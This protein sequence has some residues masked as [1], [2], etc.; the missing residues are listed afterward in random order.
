MKRVALLLAMATTLAAAPVRADGQDEAASTELFN[1]GRDAMKRGDYAVACP[2]LAESVRLKASVGALAKL[3]AC[4]EHEHR[5]VSAFTRW[6]QAL[7][8]ARTTA[9]ERLSDVQRELARV[10]ALVPKLVITGAP[11]AG[12]DASIRVDDTTMSTAASLGVA[13]PVEPGRHAVLASAPG[14]KPWT[15]TIDVAPGGATTSIVVPPLED[16]P[17][18]VEAPPV[19]SVAPPPTQTQQASAATA[20]SP[21]VAIPPSPPSRSNP[22]RMVGMVSAGVGLATI[23]VGAAYGIDA[24]RRRDDAHCAGTS[25]PDGASAASLNA[26]KNSANWSTG[27][28]ATGAALVAGGVVLWFFVGADHVGVGGRWGGP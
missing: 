10:D 7:N 5:L 17:P 15:T 16:A 6:Q 22:W 25:C 14:K 11:G 3:A 24:L 26:A 20:P 4:E 23:A 12:A 18:P 2:K 27:L 8:L 9:D 28:V 13:L 21:L 1:A 19:A